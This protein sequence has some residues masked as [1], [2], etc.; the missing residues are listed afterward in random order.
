MKPE[1]HQFEDKLLEFAYG[2][3]PPNEAVAVDAH[4]RE[5]TRC[6]LSLSEISSVRTAMKQ[7]PMEPAPEAGLESLLAY[8]AQHAKLNA[9]AK[10]STPWWRRL[11]VPVS[12][13]MA[14]VV[15]GVLAT[16]VQTV[17]DAVGAAFEGVAAKEAQV[18]VSSP[19]VPAPVA[20]SVVASPKEPATAVARDEQA[21]LAEPSRGKAEPHK[22]AVLASSNAAGPKAA[23]AA[24]RGEADFDDALSANSPERESS[25]LKAKQ[26]ESAADFGLNQVGPGGGSGQ[27]MG[28]QKTGQGG[29]LND[30][31]SEDA[32]THVYKNDN[33]D[34]E[35][36]QQAESKKQEVSSAPP[37]PVANKPSLSLGTRAP[38][39]TA[40]GSVG[41]KDV[42]ARDD[43][44]ATSGFGSTTADE[45][46]SVGNVLES[47][48]ANA[49]AANTRGDS[50]SE[51]KECLG[52][53]N[54]GAE[55]AQRA[56]SLKRVC[57]A[58][59]SMG[60]PDRA[61]PYCE[62]LLREFGRTASAKQVAL[63][64]SVDSLGTKTKKTSAPRKG[65]SDEATEPA[66]A[67][68]TQA[69]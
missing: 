66:P 20:P 1:V 37:P 17:P 22:K 28:L 54:S 67:K 42:R 7:L 10:V 3:L 8:A 4:V 47:Q 5:C 64:R 30:K 14:L 13:V 60:Q 34:E 26:A 49:R 69:Q 18:V 61:E 46:R 48:L 2:E 19:A 21:A 6:T 40:I 56:E 52:V 45:K 24:S 43:T 44:A 51:I 29:S 62:A 63:R 23:A 55:G 15:V 36:R 39:P 35:R 25:R 12:S 31:L 33:S 58:Y 32:P 38:Q 50:M 11:I 65:S 16:R 57:D 27:G 53:L 59:D 41:T 68:P 9:R